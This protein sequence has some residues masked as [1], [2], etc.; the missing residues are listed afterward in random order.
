M[1]ANLLPQMA[2][3]CATSPDTSRRALNTLKDKPS[4]PRKRKREDEE[5]DAELKPTSPARLLDTSSNP[6]LNHVVNQL[7]FSRLSQLPLSM[8]M[9]NLPSELKEKQSGKLD[10]DELRSLIGSAA[11][12][13]EVRRVGK[14]AAGAPLESEYYYIP[15]MDTDDQRRLAVTDGLR[16][17]SLRN[18][19]K[20]HK[21]R[22]LFPLFL[23]G[24]AA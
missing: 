16:K 14:D 3:F 10:Y 4:S 13:G 19:R 6:I 21:V 18:C 23:F 20:Q 15:E 17:P 24:S 5:D 9:K 22:L 12:I 11:C 7:A 2:S 1:G 8:V